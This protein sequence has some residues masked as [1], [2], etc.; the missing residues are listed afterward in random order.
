MLQNGH[1][2]ITLVALLLRL[3]L[4]GTT[5]DIEASSGEN[6]H[7]LRC[8]F[9]YHVI[10]S[11]REIF[12][13]LKAANRRCNGSS[14]STW[15]ARLAGECGVEKMLERDNEMEDLARKILALEAESKKCAGSG[16]D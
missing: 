16:L 10:A 15:I 14:L 5:G 7:T 11:F 2:L 13:E 8:A 6:E 1:L 9:V 4:S 3:E 12:D